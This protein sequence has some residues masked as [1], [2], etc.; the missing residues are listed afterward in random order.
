M[1]SGI[2]AKV[3]EVQAKLAKAGYPKIPIEV[4]VRDLGP[5]IAG[6]ALY[7]N[8]TIIISEAYF[9]QF[10]DTMLNET[11]PHEVCHQYVAIYFPY[12][13]QAHGPEF[14]AL[15]R[16]LGLQGSTYHNMQLKG[17]KIRRNAVK[18]YV[19]LSEI[20][21]AQVLLTSQQHTKQQAT[22]AFRTRKGNERLVYAGKVITMKR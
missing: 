22:G 16:T 2:N 10:P 13:K 15:M 7:N 12:A 1:L 18:R 5:R 4:L 6:R 11:V 19:Y 8:R 20:T 21:K 17:V 14:R 3:V 9:K